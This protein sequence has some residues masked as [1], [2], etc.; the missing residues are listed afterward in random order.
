MT[1]ANNIIKDKIIFGQGK[2]QFV[3]LTKI[4][5][6]IFLYFIL[7]LKLGGKNKIVV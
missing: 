5:E 4:L 7:P 6:H 1:A 2:S 3:Y